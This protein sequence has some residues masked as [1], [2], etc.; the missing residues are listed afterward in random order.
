MKISLMSC[1]LISKNQDN[2]V[3]LLALNAFLQLLDLIKV[4]SF[5]SGTGKLLWYL[6]SYFAFMISSLRNWFFFYLLVENM[7]AHPLNNLIH[8]LNIALN[9]FRRK[10]RFPEQLFSGKKI[11]LIHVGGGSWDQCNYCI[12]TFNFSRM[13]LIHNLHC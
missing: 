7:S 1:D 11:L 12:K 10:Y 9:W 13:N 4:F 5:H 6:I 3:L 8:V 2:F